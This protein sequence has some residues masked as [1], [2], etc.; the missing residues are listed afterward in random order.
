MKGIYLFISAFVS[1][2]SVMRSYDDNDYDSYDKNNTDAAHLK[3]K[4]VIHQRYLW[5]TGCVR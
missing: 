1:R 5:N 2:E 4:K 3:K